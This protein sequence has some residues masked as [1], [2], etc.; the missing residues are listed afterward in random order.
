VQRYGEEVNGGAETLC[1][2]VAE[3]L[4]RFV[5]IEV[6]TTTALDHHTW[7]QHYPTG[8]TELNGV[9]VHRFPVTRRRKP[10]AFQRLSE[11]ILR[12]PHTLLDEVAWMEAQGPE[13]PTLIDHL[14]EHR[15]EYDTFVFFTYLYYTTY[16]G[17]QIAPEKSILVPTAHDEAPIH[18]DIFRP[19]FRSAKAILY[20]TDAEKRFVQSLFQIEHIPSAVTGIG[21]ESP[22]AADGARFR[23]KYGIEGPFMLYAGR[24]EISKNCDELFDYYQSYGRAHGYEV[25]LVLLGREGMEIPDNPGVLALGFVNEQDKFDALQA[26]DFLVLPSRFESLSIA[27]LEAW[28]VGTPVVAN[29]RSEVL[30]EHCLRSNG[31]L[32]YFSYEEFAAAVQ[33]LMDRPGLRRSL[34]AAGQRYVAD[35]YG[36]ERTEACYLNV[37]EL[38]TSGVRPETN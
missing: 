38:V 3:R 34:G 2:S 21:M 10:K 8:E 9:T 14:R 36:W 26:A 32:F 29:G 4:N 13:T 6:L 31:G 17:L 12:H 15:K 18:L 35:Q 25:S 27:S 30:K 5:S 7:A 22:P 20:L 24:I 19:I 28:R 33:L 37:L 23:R 11:R 16:F 1:R